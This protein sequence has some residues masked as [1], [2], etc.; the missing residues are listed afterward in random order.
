MDRSNRSGRATY[1]VSFDQCIHIAGG[2]I[3]TMLAIAYHSDG[4]TNGVKPGRM[5]N[6][7][8]VHLFTQ[9]PAQ[10]AAAKK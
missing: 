5:G 2:P 4:K 7:A 3:G 6:T 1:S 10:N 9:F 8:H